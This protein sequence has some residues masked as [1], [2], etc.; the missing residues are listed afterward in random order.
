MNFAN[1][2]WLYCTPLIVI[3]IAGIL[4]FG[5]GRRDAL[6]QQFAA[7]R[8]LDQ[9]TEKADTQRILVKGGLILLACALIG[10]A[11]ARPQYGVNFIERKT[12]GLDIVF[13]LDSSKS[14]LATDLRPTRLDRAR[15]AILDLVNQLESDRIGLVVFAGNAFLQTP[16]TLDYAAFREN[17]NAVGPSSIS[18]GGSNIGQALREAAKAFPKDNNFKIV[19]LLTDGED[20]EE[21]AVDVARQIAK[22]GITVY[23]IGIGTPEGT[24]LKVRTENDKEEF[25]RDSSGQPVRS[26]LDEVTLQKISQLTGGSYSRLAGQSLQRLY[27]SVLATLPRDERESELQETQIERYQWVLLAAV[28]CLVT[29]T[30]IRRRKTASGQIFIVFILVYLFLPSLSY[31]EAPVEASADETIEAIEPGKHSD[32]P[33]ILYNQAHSSLTAGDYVKAI[34][35]YEMAIEYSD[36]TELEHNALYNMAHANNQLGEEALQAQDFAAAIDYWKKAGALFKSANELNSNDSESLEDAKQ[37]EERRKALED[38]LNQQ[39][40]QQQQQQKENDADNN[41]KQTDSETEADGNKQDE[42]EPS[43]DD[44]SDQNKMSQSDENASEEKPSKDNESNPESADHENNST[45][46]SDEN[47]TDNK[48]SSE[49]TDSDENSDSA[50]EST[51]DPEEDMQ[52]QNKA[53]G[54]DKE[55]NDDTE[56]DGNSVPQ[57]KSAENSHSEGT[58]E[59]VSVSEDMD[60]ADA[61]RLLDSLQTSERLLPFTETSEKQGKKRETRDW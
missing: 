14:M 15:L 1:P 59:T 10:I 21:Q 42:G 61:Q 4:I 35:R 25:V 26:R 24:Y 45:E 44:S 58:Q 16:P 2:V 48:E 36:D 27:T 52:E 53:T 28:V 51:R 3:A 7:A 19:I 13:V 38:F 57:K 50:A 29:E 17:L 54:S 12:R 18:R 20:L 40:Q 33:R 41:Q 31:A 37:M 34:E 5:L 55:E 32:D 49:E 47:S 22:D 8:L 30:L 56:G 43:S 11:L 9:L 39:Q 23:S 60:I 6:L 46:K